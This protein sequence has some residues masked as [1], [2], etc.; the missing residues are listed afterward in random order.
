MEDEY[1]S[2]YEYEK[3]VDPK[4]TNIPISQKNIND[5]DYG[6]T[7]IEFSIY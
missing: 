1:I 2:V 4:L 3:N 6:I 5:C 7:F